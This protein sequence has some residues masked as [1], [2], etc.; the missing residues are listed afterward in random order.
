MKRYINF[1]KKPI[2]AK[3]YAKRLVLLSLCA[4]MLFTAFMPTQVMAFGPFDRPP[5][6]SV[7]KSSEVDTAKEQAI[8]DTQ[9]HNSPAPG[10]SKPDRTPQRELTQKRTASSSTYLNKD[11]T[12]TLKF[13]TKQRNY[14]K[15]GKWEQIDN[16]LKAVESPKPQAN[17]FQSITGQAPKSDPPSIFQAK[18]GALSLAMKPLSEGVTVVAG[19]KSFVIKPI[20]ANNSLPEQKDATTVVYRNAWKGIDLEYEA[21]GEQL[22]ENII[23]KSKDAITELDFKIEGGKLIDDPNNPGQF[24]V[25]GLEDDY[26]FG[27]L[28]VLTHDKGILEN[29][30]YATQAKTDKNAI[31]VTLDKKWLASLPAESYPVTVDPSFGK[32]D[33]DN[34]T[35]MFKSNGYSCMGNTCWIQAGTLNDG[36]WKHWRS[37]IHFPY[38]ELAGKKVLGANIHAYYNPN[39]N[40]DPNQRYLFMGHANCI[41]WECRGTHLATV[42][43]AGDFDVDV[44]NRL[45]A[46]VNAG[47]MGAAWSFWGEEVPYKTFKTYSDMSFSVVYDTPTPVATPVEPADKQVTISTQPTLRVNS[48]GDADGDAVQYYYRVSTSP[49]A[50]TGA[51]INSGWVSA[52]QWTI[53]DGILQDGT[54]YYW[55]VYTKGATETNPNWVRS[56]KVDLR[57]G[58][59]STQAYDTVGPIGVDLAT[60]NATTSTETHNMSALGG[61]IGLTMDYN[62][63]SKP[64]SGLVGQYWNVSS[65]NTAPSG[66]PVMTTNDQ[67]INFNWPNGS[68]PGAGINTDWFAVKWKGYFVAP[69][70]GAYKFGSSN[71]DAISI[72]VNGQLFGGGCYGSTPCYN[73]E[74]IQLAAGQVVPIEIQFTEATGDAYVR[75]YVKGAVP[76]QILNRDWLRT[77]ITPSVSQYGLAGRYYTYDGTPNFPESN[78]DPMRLM[79]AR[80]DSKLSFNWGGGGPATGLQADAFMAKWTGYITVPKTGSYK[81]GAVVDDGIRIKLNNGLF[82]AQQTVLDV[83][84]DGERTSWSGDTNLTAGQQVPITIEYYERGGPARFTLLVRDTNGNEQEMP[85]KWL[86]P[87]ATALPDAWR[88]GV[89]VD[90]NVGY[91]RLRVAGQNI[92]LED[93]TRATHEYTWTGSGYKPPVNEDGQL[94]RNANNTYTLLDTDGRTY[95]FDAEGKLTSLT[96]ATDDRKPANLKYEYSGDP[97]RLMKITDGVTNSRFGT[98]HYKSVNEDGNCTVPSGFDAAPDGMLCAF[99][100]SDGDIT[101]FYYKADQLA[102]VEKPGEEKIDYGYDTL[103]RI[104]TTRDATANDAITASVRL[105]DASLQ[106]ELSYDQLGRARAI[107]APAPTNGADRVEHTLDYQ[108]AS[109]LPLGRF[110]KDQDS[111]ASTLTSIPGYTHQARLG[112]VLTS[113]LPGTHAV[114]SCQINWDEFISNDANCEG[115]YKLGLLGYVYDSPNASEGAT[116]PLQ[117]CVYQP[118]GDHFIWP[119]TSCDG[120]LNE[121]TQGYILATPINSGSTSM[122]VV[123]AQQPHGFSKKIEYD[124][125]LRTVKETDVSNVSNTTEWDSVK[126]LELSKTDATG[127]KSTTI[128]DDDDK[129]VANYGPAP[130]AWF[131]STRVPLPAYAAQVPKTTTGYDEGFVGPSVN[132]YN[133]KGS[134]FIGSPKLVTQGIDQTQKNWLGRAFNTNPVSFTPDSGMDGYGF[135]ATG[136]IRFPSTGTYTF[137]IFH[138]DGA[139]LSIEDQS[140]I[141]NWDYRS[142]GTAQAVD[143]GTF[144]VTDSSKPYRF[145]YDYLHVGNPGAAELWV[146]GPGITDTNNGLGTSKP[147]FLT[148]NYALTTSQTAYDSQ[149]GNVTTTT[150]YSKPEYGLVDKT[151]LDPTG[152]NYQSTA[153][154]EA[155]GAGYMRQ[156]SKTLP[157]GGTTTYQHYGPEETR[158]NPCTSEVES[159]VQAGRPKGKVEADPDGAGSQT[160]RTSETVYNHSGEVVATRY[161]SDPWTCTTYD[162][163]GRVLTTSIPAIGSSSARTI[164]NNYAADGNPLITTTTDSSGTI[165]VEN[166]LLGRTLKYTDAKGKQTTNSYDK[167]G[168][169]TSRTS[170]LGTESYEYDS[171]DRLTKQ[172]LDGVT[173]ATVAYDQYSRL[174]TVQYPSGVSMSNIS[175]DTLGRENGTTFTV[176][177]QQYTDTIERYV[178]GDI[179]QGTE[180]GV[181]KSYIY[182]NAGRLTGATIGSNTFS[183]EFGTPDVACG[184]ISGANP[185]AARNGNRTKMTMNG[186]STTYCYDMADRL[187]SSSDPTLTTPTYDSHGNTTSLG[188]A[189]HKTEF[190]YDSSDRNRTIKSGTAETVYT[191]DAQDRIVTREHKLNGT[192]DS[193][194]SYGFTGSGDSPDFLLDAA[195]TVTQKYLTLPGDVIVTIKPNSQSAGATTYSLPNIH[196]DIYLT[197]DADGAVKSTHQTGPFGEQLP[198]QTTPQNTASGTSWNYVGQHQK[199]TDQ[200]TSPI[201][202]GIIQMGARMYV[203]ALGRFLQ[204][205]PVEGGTDNSYAYA[206][207]P[208]NEEDLDGRVIPVVIVLGGVAVR[209][210]APAVAR[211]AV[212]YMGKQAV[213]QVVKKTVVQAPKKVVQK[214][215]PKKTVAPPAQNYSRKLPDGRINS[216]GKFRAANKQGEMIGAR[217]VSQLNPRTGIMRKWNETL[218]MKGNVRQVRPLKGNVKTKHYRYDRNGKYIG[219]W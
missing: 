113:Q 49:D 33:Q 149:L 189:T 20:G 96:S 11:G 142:E 210:A 51:V 153:T 111:K 30:Q 46:A 52:T 131:D 99:K 135:S 77:E 118:T 173:F 218:D 205:D 206:N 35:W 208:V 198:N 116:V 170:P 37:Y 90:G 39:A 5:Q 12:K 172:K 132:W 168:K 102:R 59:D 86:T 82:G 41:G 174:A 73:N 80:N 146:A 87:K 166:D 152:L 193:N 139:R 140:L 178:S 9:T 158:D 143:T 48:V 32:W 76:E 196:G 176:N 150:S 61:S 179:K 201:S 91:E 186:V 67:D 68:S 125:L 6:P 121:G 2:K 75:V 38:P 94:T 159:I 53:P 54:T 195:G 55:H 129:P 122:N 145:Q 144:T 31:R 79:M 104:S 165:R 200:D 19:D 204:V 93:S 8:V 194:V 14:Q 213:K 124:S 103:G 16:T 98:L 154:Y 114:Y 95:V 120:R 133:V 126:D 26:Q 18:A 197:V 199:L 190:T 64:K 4:V 110:S 28:T 108:G 50:E 127:L 100:T 29:K 182:D 101:R 21:R 155:P 187:V 216:Y 161:N 81:L 88:L 17:F 156:T 24:A 212:A 7:L 10:K 47:D 23:V 130:S 175:R 167:Y 119:N 84:Q 177:G 66:N 169:L 157:G 56:F 147:N 211:A 188:D 203:P 134:S 163:R 214:A 13:S 60:G 71:D 36:G 138:D 43:T 92:I 106:T 112:Y 209:A 40:P 107:K 97:S 65:G 183:Y 217:K 185:N 89:D 117:R 72:N 105:D 141:S 74:S 202:G 15:N 164:T 162:A 192:T 136:K 128:Y 148:P 171:Y 62:T 85:V 22:K 42:L 1:A 57:T 3:G 115:Q 219:S 180:N 207:D 151:T 27:A 58:K 70:S 63:P 109:S 44:T 69:N 181:A 78:G 137:K 45:Q 215:A 123:G 191:R 34:T 83:W 184:A 25:A 160:P